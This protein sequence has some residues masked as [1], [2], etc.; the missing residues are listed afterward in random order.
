MLISLK[1]RCEDIAYFREVDIRSISKGKK[2]NTIQID[3]VYE[4][5]YYIS[6][7]AEW[8]ENGF[9]LNVKNPA[10]MKVHTAKVD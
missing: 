3:F 6:S 9:M 1:R 2:E 8:Q 7:D 4:G 5:E 10:R